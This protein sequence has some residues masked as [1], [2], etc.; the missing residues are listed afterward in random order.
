MKKRTTE[1]SKVGDILR[2]EF[3][4]PMG[5]TEKQLAEKLEC[6]CEDVTQLI[7]GK[8][9]LKHQEAV[10]LSQLFKTSTD[11]WVNLQSAHDRWEAGR[12]SVR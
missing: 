7:E 11:F 1:P 12:L 5:V 8:R 4:K 9:A 6:S 3:L 10:S 2:E